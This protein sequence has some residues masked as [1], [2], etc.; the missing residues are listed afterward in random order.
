MHVFVELYNYHWLIVGAGMIVGSNLH[1][2]IRPRGGEGIGGKQAVWS[3]RS[4]QRRLKLFTA[5]LSELLN[6]NLPCHKLLYT[7]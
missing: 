5:M 7:A 3:L 1:R 2:A 4:K 6:E